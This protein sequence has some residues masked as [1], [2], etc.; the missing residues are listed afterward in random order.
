MTECVCFSVWVRR[1]DREMTDGKNSECVLELCLEKS[2]WCRSSGFN[3]YVLSH[4]VKVVAVY[5]TE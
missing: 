4:R 5:K 2:P 1:Q 3:K